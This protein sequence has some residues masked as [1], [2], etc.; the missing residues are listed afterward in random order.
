VQRGWG[1]ERGLKE[2]GAGVVAGAARS[3]SMACKG[4]LL[5]GA[6]RELGLLKGQGV[7]ENKGVCGR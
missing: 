4:R 3:W 7:S 6:Y 1:G 2:L 5:G